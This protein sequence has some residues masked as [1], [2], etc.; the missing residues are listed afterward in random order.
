M[1]NPNPMLDAH[2][3]Y[4]NGNLK[5]R[6]RADAF[7]NENYAQFWCACSMNP[8]WK[9]AHTVGLVAIIELFYYQKHNE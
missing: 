2:I 7:T 6:Y 8:I 4:V 9:T 3:K 1:C 5:I